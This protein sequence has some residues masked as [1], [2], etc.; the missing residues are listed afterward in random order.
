MRERTAAAVT[1]SDVP[2]DERDAM[3]VLVE[4]SVRAEAVSVGGVIRSSS[5]LGTVKANGEMGQTT[6]SSTDIAK[7]T[8]F[9]KTTGVILPVPTVYTIFLG[10]GKHLLFA[11]GAQC[12]A[13]S[14]DPNVFL[15]MS[16]LWLWAL[17]D[18]KKGDR[19]TMDL[20]TTEDKLQRQ[21]ACR[22]GSPGCRG[23]ITGYDEMPNANGQQFFRK[24]RSPGL[25]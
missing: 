3:M 18:I 10:G 15:D 13:H 21:F 9:F 12:L 17:K 6:Y 25:G 2:H 11:G 24:R 22:C 8:T 1:A 23:W 4:P 16:E 20:A 19:L 14:C 7:G 5:P